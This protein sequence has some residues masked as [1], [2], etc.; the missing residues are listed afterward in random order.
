M[1]Y[2]PICVEELAV[3]VAGWMMALLALLAAAVERSNTSQQTSIPA[4]Y[5]LRST[6]APLILFSFIT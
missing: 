1:S 4:Y 6:V 2:L 5:A 3:L